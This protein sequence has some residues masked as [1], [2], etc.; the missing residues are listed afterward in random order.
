ML[1]D[2]LDAIRAGDRA[3]FD[4]LMAPELPVLERRAQELLDPRLRTILGAD[5]LVQ[6]T[7][8]HA[9]RYLVSRRLA[10]VE[11]LHKWL[12][13]ILGNVATSARRRHL[14]TAKR[15]AEPIS[16]ETRLGE[17]S[18]TGAVALGGAIPEQGTSPSLS[19]E[20]RELASYL[21]RL[22]EALRPEHREVIRLVKLGSKKVPEAAVALAKTEFATRKL[23]SRA[24]EECAAILPR[25]LGEG[26]ASS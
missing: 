25:L 7:L 13:T 21:P 20:K 11:A 6:E 5:D 15:S 18:S 2:L 1:S 12:A 8:L 16:L 19:A 24:L 17:T 3:A 22:L 26:R 14:L 4:R 23:L 10:D 9:Y